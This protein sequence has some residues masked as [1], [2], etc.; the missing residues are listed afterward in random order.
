VLGFPKKTQ[1]SAF[2]HVPNNSNTA[3]LCS[4]YIDPDNKIVKLCLAA[5][6]QEGERERALALCEKAWEEAETP[7]E[8]AI[9]AH[10]LARQQSNIKDKLNWDEIALNEAAQMDFVARKGFYPSLYLNAGKGHEDLNQLDQA[11]KYF[12]LA[13]MYAEELPDDDY[14]NWVRKGIREAVGRIGE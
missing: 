7:D 13:E 2:W 11:K 12:L 10:Y 6:E 14:S 8:K 1:N 3:Y 5:L 4:M 9:A